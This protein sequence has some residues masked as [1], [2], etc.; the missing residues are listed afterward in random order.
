MRPY[1]QS[2]ERL[3]KREPIRID[4]VKTSAAIGDKTVLVT[5]AGG[6]IGSA[7]CKRLLQFHP[8]RLVLLEKSEHALYQVALDLEPESR[9]GSEIATEATGSRRWET[10]TRRRALL[11][12][13]DDLVTTVLGDLCDCELL[14]RVFDNHHVDIVFHTAAYKHVSLLEFHPHAAIRNNVIGTDRLVDAVI[15][16]GVPRLVTLS[17]DKAV[18]PISVMGASKRIAEMDVIGM[19]T[20]ECRMT[21]VRLGNVLGSQGS[22]IPRLADQIRN[23]RPLTVTD[24]RAARYFMTLEEAADLVLAA[25]WLGK[26][27]DLLVP[28]LGEP[29]LIVDL[30][31]EMTRA[32]GFPDPEIVFNA[33]GPGEKL[34]E[35]ML[36]GD[37]RA[38]RVPGTPVRRVVDMKMPGWEVGHY[39]AELDKVSCAGDTEG[40][41]EMI[42]R[43]LPEYRP[44][45]LLV[46]RRGGHRKRS[47]D[48]RPRSHRAKRD[49]PMRSRRKS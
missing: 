35:Q 11:E 18:N 17:T 30:A 48:S 3:L 10:T 44:S 2:I 33:L 28:D 25:V 9:P 36:A 34:V 8:G 15:R 12:G 43:M 41:I 38:V 24:P 47:D 39:V 1:P 31:R 27:G 19:S 7:V 5:G 37:E 29:V 42:C 40:L 13:P 45:P 16:H 26:G 46:A 21:A 4:N 6:S 23:R 22:V 20:P 49:A 14:E 32:A